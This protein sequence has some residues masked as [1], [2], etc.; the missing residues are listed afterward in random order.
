M[1]EE[2]KRWMS[3]EYLG[4]LDKA[5]QIRREFKDRP[6]ALEFITGIIT[7]LFVDWHKFHGNDVKHKI[8]ELNQFL[9]LEYSY[10]GLVQLFN[11]QP[12]SNPRL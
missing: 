1:Q 5:D 12:P 8:P 7:D 4:I 2:D 9:T 3:A 10:E 6:R 11:L